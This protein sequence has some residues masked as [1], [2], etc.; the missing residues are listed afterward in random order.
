MIGCDGYTADVLRRAFPVG[1]PVEERFVV[2]LTAYF[3]ESGTHDGSEAVSVAGYL[4]TDEMWSAFSL[5]WGPILR[6]FDLK[7]FHMTDFALSKKQFRG[8]SESKRRACFGA[9]LDVIN[10]NVIGSVGIVV[11]LGAYLRE[12]APEAD[13]FV[14]GPYGLAAS[15][16]FLHLGKT[17]RLSGVRGLVAY[18]YEAGAVGAGQVAKVFNENME[19]PGNR[20]YQRLLSIGFQPKYI[21]PEDE[22]VRPWPGFLPLQAADI[23]A[24]E[25]YQQLP[26]QLGRDPRSPRLFSLTSL[27]KVPAIWVHS[28]QE[29][30]AKW[31]HI[32]SIRLQLSKDELDHRVLEPAPHRDKSTITVEQFQERWRWWQQ[33]NPVGG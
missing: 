9:L 11:P 28:E 4:A 15:Q 17:L 31:S 33:F 29:E 30:L 24:Y 3:D 18:V 19:D 13:K 8:W 5:E 20:E 10:R 1:V 12:F 32:I 25:L 26:R 16:C 2:S 23:L 6:E 27:R 7:Y 21:R 22:T 14:G